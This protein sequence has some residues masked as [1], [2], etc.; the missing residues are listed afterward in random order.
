MK[1]ILK[2]RLGSLSSAGVATLLTA[3]AL[4]QPKRTVQ[5][6]DGSELK[7]EG[8]T[9]GTNLFVG[10]GLIERLVFKYTGRPLGTKFLKWE[11]RRMVVF[12]GSPGTLNAI[13]SLILCRR[14]SPIG[15]PI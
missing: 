13:F 5:L 8:V 2:W 12:Y 3:F 14:D 6:P 15:S 9:Y 11:F 1:R 4:C 7:L 10:G